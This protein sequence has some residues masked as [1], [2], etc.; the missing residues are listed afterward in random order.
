MDEKIGRM[1]KEGWT[2]VPHK[3][4]QADRDLG[5]S[6]LLARNGEY[7]W[8]GASGQPSPATAADVEKW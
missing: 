5:G 6:T 3:S 1:L 7:V 2:T 4:P 8:V